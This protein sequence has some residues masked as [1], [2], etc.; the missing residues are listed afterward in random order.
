ME[1]WPGKTFGSFAEKINNIHLF[2]A[3]LVAKFEF[4]GF[5]LK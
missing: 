3:V 5:P 4:A 2:F 1:Y